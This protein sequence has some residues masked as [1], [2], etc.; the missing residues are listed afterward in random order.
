VQQETKEFG[1]IRVP[2]S[3]NYE[4][5]N[6]TKSL[7]NWL[8]LARALLRDDY[9]VAITSPSETNWDILVL[10]IAKLRKKKLIFWGESWHW[11]S[12]TLLRKTYY[13][14]FFKHF[15]NWGDSLIAM[16]EKQY[17]FYQYMLN[18]RQGIFRAPKYVIS[19]Q[20]KDATELLKRLSIQDNRI[21]GKKIVLYM[22]QIIDRK[23]LDYLIR[24][25]KL[26]EEEMNDVYLLIVGSGTFE[27]HCKRLSKNL[28]IKNIMFRGYSDESDIELY[29]NLCSLFV[30]PSIFLNDYP[31]PDGYVLF[32]AMSVG[33]PLVITDAVG[34]TPELVRDGIN[35]FVVGNK[36]VAELYKAM[37]KILTDKDLEAK[38]GNK[39]QELFKEKISLAGQFETFKKAIENTKGNLSVM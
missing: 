35:G 22:S 34:A 38:M 23:G 16:G 18:K 14:I 31:E 29:H 19:Y 10:L 5:I 4:N 15:L 9:E 24:A 7:T 25:F 30:L 17:S 11:P 26:L 13:H 33:K 12:N 1:G 3:W 20:K 27:S 8:L 6:V 37:L 28:D 39:S 36:N 21:L 2:A 32:E